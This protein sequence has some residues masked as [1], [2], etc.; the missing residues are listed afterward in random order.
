MVI[1][2]SLSILDLSCAEILQEELDSMDDP[3][4]TERS[5][6]TKNPP[7]GLLEKWNESDWTVLNVDFGIPLFDSHLNGQVCQRITGRHLWQRETLDSLANVQKSLS[8]QLLDF[9]SNHVDASAEGKA[10][11]QDVVALPT[12][13]LLFV[14]GKL[15][16]W[17][18][19]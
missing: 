8:D 19:N 17:H 5:E 12:K 15:N 2:L 14:D 11:S 4:Q 7:S 9:I 3:S 10:N 18:G 1:I 13:N 6:R 16:V